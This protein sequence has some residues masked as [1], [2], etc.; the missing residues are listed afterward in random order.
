MTAPH[1][2]SQAALLS[3][4]LER[5]PDRPPLQQQL[6]GQL[7]EALLAGRLGPGRRLPSSRALAGELGCSRN[8]VIGAF[9]QLKAE[10]YLECRGGSGS[11]VSPV[12]PESLQVASAAAPARPR[13]A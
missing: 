5:E 3:L 11:Y 13:P 7:R 12:L 2:R 10:G 6:Y 1:R 8:T 9:E 4:A